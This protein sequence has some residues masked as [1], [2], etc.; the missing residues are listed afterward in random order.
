MWVGRG[1]RTVPFR[2]SPHCP[3]GFGG[4]GGFGSLGGFRGIGAAGAGAGEEETEARCC[5]GSCGVV[6]LA[7]RIV[8]LLLYASESA[9]ASDSASS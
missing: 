1:G 9:S 3:R 6:M 7:F 4:L 5:A 8:V 2:R